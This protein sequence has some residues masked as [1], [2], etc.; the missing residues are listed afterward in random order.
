MPALQACTVRRCTLVRVS[1][2]Q[3]SPHVQLLSQPR[4]GPTAKRCPLQH[5]LPVAMAHLR[6]W[7]GA[8][9]L[10]RRLPLRHRGCTAGTSARR[11]EGLPFPE[12][13]LKVQWISRGYVEI[14]GAR[15]LAGRP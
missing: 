8:R 9:W 4:H 3:V 10:S 12:T 13:H 14:A 11:V 7:W 5:T 1:A 15:D 6:L 2:V